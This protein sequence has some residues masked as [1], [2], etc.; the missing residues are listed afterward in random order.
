MRGYIYRISILVLLAL[1]GL[2]TCGIDTLTY[3]DTEIKPVFISQNPIGL[4][5]SGPDN[6]PLPPRY[7]GMNLYYRIYASEAEAINDR[8]RL[9]QRQTSDSVP[10]SA[11]PFFLETTL[12][13]LRPVRT[14]DN[15]ID[16]RQ[17]PT[18]PSSFDSESLRIELIDGRLFLLVGINTSYEL[19][20]NLQ[21]VLYDFSVLPLDE[22][23]DY[24]NIQPTNPGPFYVQFF[25]ASYGFN[26]LGS[27]PELFS[28]AVFLGRI[29]LSETE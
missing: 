5:F 4:I 18:I 6:P 2:T 14:A 10:G 21:G 20:R 3:L 8:S 12:K 11:V 25:A 28:D 23:V 29:T 19:R 16:Y 9:D 13:Y 22:D 27:N 15:G 24:N 7:S 1:L 17:P 26:F